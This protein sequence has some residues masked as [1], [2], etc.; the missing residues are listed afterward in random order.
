MS[1][2]RPVFR[3]I[4]D[5]DKKK[6]SQS[7]CLLTISVGQEVHESEKFETTVDLI[8]SSFDSCILLIDDSL[9]RHTMALYSGED[10]D[11][12]YN[13]SIKAGNEWLEK[14][15]KYYEKL[16]ILKKIIR[17]DDW[18]QHEKYLEQQ[19]KIKDLIEKNK[20]YKEA[21]SLTIDDFLKRN[22]ERLSRRNNYN[23]QRAEKLCL[24]YL[25][26]ECTALCLW[27][28]MNCTFEVYPGRRNLAM[29]ETHKHFILTKDVDLLH[30]VGIKF[31]NRKQLKAQQ[32]RTSENIC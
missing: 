27:V 5:E 8:N 7:Q 25:I 11:F 2:A 24:D 14:N 3:Y 22:H 9:Q 12:F 18:L 10:A 31:K 30:A 1:T 21:F 28:E 17:W 6:F 20:S 15:K 29:A 19:T 32:F 4:S 23:L 16:T 26:E 13:A